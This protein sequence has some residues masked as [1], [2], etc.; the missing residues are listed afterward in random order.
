MTSHGAPVALPLC[1]RGSEFSLLIPIWMV[2]GIAKDIK[3]REQEKG[4]GSHIVQKYLNYYYYYSSFQHKRRRILLFY[5][6]F[7][8][9][10]ICFTA[11]LYKFHWIYWLL[12]E[13]YWIES[14]R[15]WNITTL[16]LLIGNKYEF[17]VSHFLDYVNSICSWGEIGRNLSLPFHLIPS[18]DPTVFTSLRINTI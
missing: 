8:A 17:K 15:R 13:K 10:Q 14:G 3:E 16:L 9:F 5:R 1:R 4:W 2:F 7:W 12:R 18:P 11:F 6:L